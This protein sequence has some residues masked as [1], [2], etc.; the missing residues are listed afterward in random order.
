LNVKIQIYVFYYREQIVTA[1]RNENVV[2]IAGDTGCG[3]STQVPQYLLEAGYKR[4]GKHVVCLVIKFVRKNSSYVADTIGVASKHLLLV[5]V[6]EVC[7]EGR[8]QSGCS[9]VVVIVVKMRE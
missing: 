1:I 8:V 9:D 2:I 6:G 7:T 4:I 3:K 5:S